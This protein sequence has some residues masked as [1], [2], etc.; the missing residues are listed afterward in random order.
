M[1]NKSRLIAAKMSVLFKYTALLMEHR[2]VNFSK[3]SDLMV[4]EIG[5][6]VRYIVDFSEVPENVVVSLDDVIKAILESLREATA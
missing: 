3:Y 6:D 5:K 4:F 1:A 2:E